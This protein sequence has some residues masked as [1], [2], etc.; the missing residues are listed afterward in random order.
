MIT[1]NQASA[2]REAI[3]KKYVTKAKEW[4]DNNGVKQEDGS[5]FSW[6]SFS[7]ILNGATSGRSHPVIEK[8]WFD[9]AD[10]YLSKKTSETQK[11]EKFVKKVK[12]QKS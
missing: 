4:A 2:L 6:S 11:R 8:A 1:K 12:A 10:Y 3:G 7:M 5:F 9:C